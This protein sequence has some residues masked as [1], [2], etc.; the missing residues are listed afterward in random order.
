MNEIIVLKK[1]CGNKSVKELLYLLSQDGS[2]L[3]K[4]PFW[5]QTDESNP[6]I[7]YPSWQ[8]KEHNDSNLKPLEQPMSELSGSVKASHVI[9]KANAGLILYLHHHNNNNSYGVHL[10]TKHSVIFLTFTVSNMS[11][12]LRIWTTSCKSSATCLLPSIVAQQCTLRF[13]LS[14][15]SANHFSVDFGLEDNH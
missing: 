11:F 1:V 14:T 7:S 6:L 12:P 13:K 3:E 15:I 2:L 10:C 9:P 4:D 8:S 5:R